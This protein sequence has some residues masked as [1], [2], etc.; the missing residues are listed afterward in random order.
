MPI[1]PTE[2]RHNPTSFMFF[3]LLP[4]AT[5]QCFPCKGL[6]FNDCKYHG[7]EEY[8]TKFLCSRMFFSVLL[9]SPHLAHPAALILYRSG[10]S[11]RKTLTQNN[12][13]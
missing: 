8:E 10:L 12:G 4:H 3:L 11:M 9:K 5:L 2:Q 1:P 13:L 6:H 7:V